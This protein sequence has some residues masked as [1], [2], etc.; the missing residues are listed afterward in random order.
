MPFH[1]GH[2]HCTEVAASECDTLYLILFVGG[3]GEEALREDFGHEMDS[4]YLSWAA[5]EEQIAR[6]AQMFK[7]VV[8]CVIDVSDCK[9]TDGSQN[10]D[11]ETQRVIEICG[12]IPDA[13]YSS[14]LSDTDYYTRAY[15]HCDI[16][17]VDSDRTSVPISATMI[18]GMNEDE[19][20]QWVI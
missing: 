4:G 14:E 5:R 1:K 20:M 9:N 2:L 3:H 19:R 11:M 7:N 6:A 17:C 12:G 15:P 18:R 8:P 13:V 10:W 16:R